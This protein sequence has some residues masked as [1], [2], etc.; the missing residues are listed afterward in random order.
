MRPTALALMPQAFAIIA[1]GPMGRFSR[2]LLLRHRHNPCADLRAERGNPRGARLVAKKAVDPFLHKPFL[3]APDTGLGFLR[4]THDLVRSETLGRK[5]NDLGPPGVLLRRVAVLQNRLQPLAL[6]RF[7]RDGYSRSHTADLHLCEPA[8][9]PLRDLSVRCYPL[10]RREDLPQLT[11][12]SAI[13]VSVW[14]L[15]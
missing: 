10:G 1:R 14:H 11:C 4:P 12:R 8:G 9:I 15:T 5:Q 3:P 6:R 2:R 13:V 7:H